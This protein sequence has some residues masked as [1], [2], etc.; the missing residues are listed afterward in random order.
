[1]PTTV[2]FKI[3]SI[4]ALNTTVNIS[5]SHTGVNLI[6]TF[7]DQRTQLGEC[8]R[9]VG[10]PPVLVTIDQMVLNIRQSLHID[11]N[12][13]SIYFI[14]YNLTTN[15]VTLT[16]LRDSQFA[17]VL[18]DTAGAIDITINNDAIVTPLSIDTV[19]VSD[20]TTGIPCDDVKMTITL[21][22]QA[23]NISSPIA[24]AVAANP[25]IFETVRSPDPIVFRFDKGAL[26]ATKTY[27]IPKLLTA[28][29][30]IILGATPSGGT[31]EVERLY[32]LSDL[33]GFG[34]LLT[35]EYSLDNV[36]WQTS[37]SWSGVP[38]GAITIYIRDNIGC[39]INIPVDVPVFSANLV[40][41]DA[42][43]EV[44]NAGSFR[45]KKL[46][47]WVNCGIIKNVE[48]TLSFE[49]ETK[50]NNRDFVQKF[51]TCDVIRTQIKSNYTT[52]AAK[53]VD[54]DGTEVNLPVTRMTDNL[55][56]KDVRDGKVSNRSGNIL[57]IY[58][59][60]GYTYDP[61]T[62]IQNV[63]YNLFENLMDWVNIGDFMNVEGLGWTLVTN[64]VAPTVALP[65]YVAILATLN[66]LDYADDTILKI[67]TIYNV[68][69]YNRFEFEL[70][71]TTLLGDYQIII[72]CS[73]PVFDDIEF[74]SEWI[75]VS[76]EQE[77]HHKIEWFSTKN[78]EINYGTGITNL[79]RMPYIMKLK[80]KPSDEQEIYI[81]DTKT[82]HLDSH[83]REFYE[84]N[85]LPM[86]TAIAQ[87]IV[88]LLAHNRIF[89]DGVNYL[90][91]GE[92]DSVSYGTTNL[93]S[94]KANLVKSNYV[95][96]STRQ[97]ATQA[98]ILIGSGIP[99]QINQNAKGLLWIE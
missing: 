79:I 37:N 13:L 50:I 72:N 52:N 99:L 38:A 21:S 81:T 78:N 31:I 80:W 41:Y 15:E 56:I 92:V 87:K 30:N 96:D 14:D 27:R 58:F 49:E 35:F 47:S 42:V 6:E 88:L 67:T 86:P 97:G 43:G 59:G 10:D 1:M 77:E 11:Y 8:A 76:V 46:E 83:V 45:F 54:C 23:D 68:V 36:I 5:D 34:L 98:E 20:A 93:Y 25:F 26:E 32:P 64:I 55:N 75:N 44:S 65:Y 70:D 66:D 48:N 69:D 89:I 85:L 12:Q 73:D 62:L 60:S 39:S 53:R 71:M 82:I 95:F 63:S 90:L 33:G 7:V 57:G 9:K 4:P 22:E 18:N 91:E 61:D 51:Q 28:N 16:A 29:I 19:A 94:I 3:N 2:I 40:D 17:E 74:Q 84:L 24:Q